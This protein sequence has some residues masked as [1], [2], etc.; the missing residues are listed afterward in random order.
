MK[1]KKSD[2]KFLWIFGA[3]HKEVEVFLEPSSSSNQ[4][5]E[6]PAFLDIQKKTPPPPPP[7]P[8]PLPFIRNSKRIEWLRP[9]RQI[10]PIKLQF[11]Q[12]PVKSAPINCAV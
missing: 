3:G 1:M 7:P 4:D 6:R 10:I 2:Y 5:F 12:T 11:I 9:G 8:P